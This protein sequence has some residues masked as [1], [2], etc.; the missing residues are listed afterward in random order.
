MIFKSSLYAF[1]SLAVGI[2]AFASWPES[3]AKSFNSDS[4]KHARHPDIQVPETTSIEEA[5]NIYLL[6]WFQ[7]HK[8]EKRYDPIMKR[9]IEKLLRGEITKVEFERNTISVQVSKRSAERKLLAAKVGVLKSSGNKD[10]KMYSR[11]SSEGLGDLWTSNI[12][13]GDKVADN[14]S[15]PHYRYTYRSL[16]SREVDKICKR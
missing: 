4:V 9:E 6:A 11:Y 3:E 1:V 14:K 10:W 15:H 8:E 7:D 12:I 16:W 2:P 13:A 5:C